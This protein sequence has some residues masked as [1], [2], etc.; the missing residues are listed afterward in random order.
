MVRVAAINVPKHV[1]QMEATAYVMI[2]LVI[3]CMGAKM[4]F[5]AINVT[6]NAAVNV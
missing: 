5:M 4:D 3:V 6:T 2:L 1:N